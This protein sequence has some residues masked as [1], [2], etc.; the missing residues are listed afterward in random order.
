M[1]TNPTLKKVNKTIL[2]NAVKAMHDNYIYVEFFDNKTISIRDS[3]VSVTIQDM[4]SR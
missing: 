3:K 2:L 4:G 1:T